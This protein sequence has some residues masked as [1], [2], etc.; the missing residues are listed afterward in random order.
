ML[1]TCKST[2]QS[3]DDIIDCH[4]GRNVKENVKRF[5][6]YTHEKFPCEVSC[7]KTA[8]KREKGTKFDYSSS[9]PIEKTKLQ[10]DR[11]FQCKASIL[12]YKAGTN[13]EYKGIYTRA[14]QTECGMPAGLAESSE[15][16]KKGKLWYTRL[17]IWHSSCAGMAKSGSQLGK[18]FQACLASDVTFYLY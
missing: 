17:I 7:S 1:W 14:L 5:Y 10:H 3:R 16:G 9:F 2:A 15:G 12:T 4:K 8:L 18:G 11:I 6:I 13:A